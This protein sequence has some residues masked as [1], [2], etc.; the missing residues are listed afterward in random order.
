MQHHIADVGF[1]SSRQVEDITS[2]SR[3]TIWRLRRAG[4]FPEPVSL[5]GSRVG[6][7]RRAVLN[8]IEDR[9]G[10]IGTAEGAR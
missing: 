5:G 2:L 8:W 10:S 6:Y 9:G 7:P 1:F 3:V 4:T